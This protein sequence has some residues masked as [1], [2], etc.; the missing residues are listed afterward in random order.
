M[1]YRTS[2]SVLLRR[3]SRLTVKLSGI[4]ILGLLTA[5]SLC[6]ASN[7][8]VLLLL[9]RWEGCGL[10]GEGGSGLYGALTLI[11]RGGAGSELEGPPPGG[12]GVKGLAAWLREEPQ[13]R[14]FHSDRRQ[15]STYSDLRRSR[16]CTD[17]SPYKSLPG[18]LPYKSLPITA[19]LPYISLLRSHTTHC[20]LPVHITAAL[21]YM[22]A[23]VYIR[24]CY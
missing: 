6:V 10:Y 19:A 2:T 1:R 14:L 5:Q 18:A 9:E 23:D 20:H 16:Y 22:V 12:M 11:C 4:A 15:I 3:D 8:S 21:A 17:Y 13:R 24:L 7:F